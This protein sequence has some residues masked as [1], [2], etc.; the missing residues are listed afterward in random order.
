MRAGLARGVARVVGEKSWWS[1]LG[2]K[3]G[4]AGVCEWKPPSLSF[5]YQISDHARQPCGHSL[6]SLH[7]TEARLGGCGPV[8]VRAGPHLGGGPDFR[9]GSD[10]AG[11]PPRARFGHRQR[12][13]GPS[14]FW[15][16]VR[17]KTA[18]TPSPGRVSVAR[19]PSG[20]ATGAAGNPCWQ[21]SVVGSNLVGGGYA[22]RGR[23]QLNR[24]MN[25]FD[26]GG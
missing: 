4:V 25:G 23:L 24:G 9:T 12:L 17:L 13:R 19:R 26:F 15:A 7:M 22:P 5:R 11:R 6:A 21:T 14:L 16:V 20:G 2:G 10:P 1:G 8:N 18:A 3:P